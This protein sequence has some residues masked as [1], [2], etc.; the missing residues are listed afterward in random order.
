MKNTEL[1]SCPFCGGHNLRIISC[2]ED[3]CDD[4]DCSGCDTKTFAVC[5]PIHQEGCG[6]SSGWKPTKEEAIK[7]WNNRVDFKGLVEKYQAVTE[8]N[9]E[10][11]SILKVVARSIEKLGIEQPKNC[12]FGQGLCGYPIDDCFNCPVHSWNGYVPLMKCEV[13]GEREDTE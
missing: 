9:L 3:C 13:C 12:L 6:C 1:R 7:A 5:C 4:I 8:E 2:D 10:L 11:V